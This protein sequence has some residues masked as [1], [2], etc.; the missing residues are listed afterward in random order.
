MGFAIAIPSL[1]GD[2]GDDLGA[3]LPWPY[4]QCRTVVAERALFLLQA[5]LLQAFQHLS[6]SRLQRGGFELLFFV[7]LG[8]PLEVELR[9]CLL[10]LRKCSPCLCIVVIQGMGGNQPRLGSPNVRPLTDRFFKSFDRVRVVPEGEI[11]AS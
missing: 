2:P 10:K 11:S 7:V 1:L 6:R 8:D 4:S 3:R 9:E 5:R